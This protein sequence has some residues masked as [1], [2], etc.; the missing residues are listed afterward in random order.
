V[1]EAVGLVPASGE[2]IEGN[3]PANGEAIR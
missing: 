1:L 2:H 3:L